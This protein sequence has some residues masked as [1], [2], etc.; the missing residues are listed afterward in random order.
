MFT[1]ARLLPLFAILVL[2]ACAP[3]RSGPPGQE[4][5]RTAV[6]PNGE[7]L[8]MIPGPDG[9]RDALAAWFATADANGD[10]VLDLSEMQADG[11]RWFAV[12]DLDHNGEVTA[13]ELTTVRLRINPLPE[14][15]PLQGGPD[16]DGPGRGGPGRGGA[17]E[18][19]RARSQSQADPVMAADANA[20]FRVTTAEFRAHVT[21][22]TE[23]R[24][25]GIVT[26]VQVQDACRADT[27]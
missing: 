1:P 2:A 16:G 23:A 11:A 4:Q 9:C 18:R 10:G 13:D 3:S 19:G 26:A 24:A 20:D 12:A 5:P 7:P 21:A 15:E 14:L 27:R 17:G 25:G 8:P 6:T 22:R